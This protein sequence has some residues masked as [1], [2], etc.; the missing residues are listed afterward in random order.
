[1]KRLI[2]VLALLASTRLFAGYY[3]ACPGQYSLSWPDKF[4]AYQPTDQDL[5]WKDKMVALKLKDQELP[6][7][8]GVKL[9][10]RTQTTCVHTSPKGKKT[11]F[12]VYINSTDL[13]ELLVSV[14]GDYFYINLKDRDV[15]ESAGG[16]FIKYGHGKIILYMTYDKTI[17]FDGMG[18]DGG[19]GGK[20]SFTD[21]Q[22]LWK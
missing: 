21:H 17:D 6:P 10:V 8:G 16:I 14:N 5:K 1:M 22:V 2:F 4:I 18:A 15:E 11:E 7:E 3:Q 13:N 12:P 20:V 19:N 9:F